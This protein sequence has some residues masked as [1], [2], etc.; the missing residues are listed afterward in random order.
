MKR[1]LC[2]AISLIGKP[3]VVLL[4]EPSTVS[5]QGRSQGREKNK[6]EE[7]VKEGR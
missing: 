2:V 1:R 3:K 5:S 7:V 6:R 4:D